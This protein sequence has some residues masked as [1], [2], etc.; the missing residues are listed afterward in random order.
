MSA[1]PYAGP[2]TLGLASW[3]HTLKQSSIQQLLKLSAQP[4]IIS[5]ALGLPA[6]ELFPA[7]ALARVAANLLEHD[8]VVLQYQPTLHALKAQIVQLMAW[9]GVACYEEQIFLTSGAQQAMSLLTRLLLDP[10]GQVLAEETI[11][12][13][14][15]QAIE[16]LQPRIATVPT[17]GATGMDVDAVEALLRRGRRPALIYAISD[18][19]NP[20]AVSL[21]QAKRERLVEL[22]QQHGV[23]IVEDDAYGF[24]SYVSSPLP[25]MRALDADRVFYIGSFSKI[26]APGLRVGWLIVPEELTPK[27][28]VVKEATDINTSTFTQR[29]IVAYL[30]TGAFP[31]H[32]ARLRQEYRARRDA[33]EAAL[34]LYLPPAVRWSLPDSGM[35]I[36][37][38]LPL[39]S[40]TGRLLDAAVTIAK[41]AFVPGH[42]FGVGEHRRAAHC[43]RLSFS[44]CSPA[45]ITEGI[46]RLGHVIRAALYR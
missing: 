45:R 12:S 6:A 43:M 3:A 4:D 28:A 20:V 15:L 29:L 11:Y 21:S 41:V 35:F 16:P 8:P 31:G 18:G 46:E 27:L 30:D 13:G 14:F 40:D 19:H 26:L 7:A 9:R 25:P 44:N 17:D 23:P 33:M 5:F 34:R 42:A 2:E 36:W 1:K 24:L 22:A 39:G 10:G 37:L 38:E 32:L